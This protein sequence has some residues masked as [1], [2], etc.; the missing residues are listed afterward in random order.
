MSKLIPTIKEKTNFHKGRTV[1]VRDNADNSWK[2]AF[3]HSYNDDGTFNCTL[4]PTGKLPVSW[5]YCK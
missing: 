2:E 5:K 1:L 3:F 4:I